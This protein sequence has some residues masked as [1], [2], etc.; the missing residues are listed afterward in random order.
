MKTTVA[1]RGRVTIPKELREKLGIQPRT[2]LNFRAENGRLIAEKQDPDC[3]LAMVIG[4]IALDRST[5]EIIADLRG[6]H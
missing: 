2:V 5:N 1:S 3:P 4:C 6:Y